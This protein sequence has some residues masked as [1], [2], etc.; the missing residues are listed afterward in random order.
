MSSPP[1]PEPDQP[2]TCGAAPAGQPRRRRLASGLADAPC[3]GRGQAGRGADRRSDPRGG[4]EAQSSLSSCRAGASGGGQCFDVRTLIRPRSVIRDVRHH[5][6]SPTL[7]EAHHRNASRSRQ[8]PPVELDPLD[9][10]CP[11]SCS[12]PAIR[13]DH[14]REFST[15][16][17]VGP[18]P[19]VRGRRR[20][21]TPAFPRMSQRTFVIFIIRKPAGPNPQIETHPRPGGTISAGSARSELEPV[22]RRRP[23]LARPRQRPGWAEAPG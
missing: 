1:R 18:V 3:P 22:A 15:T 9:A 8:A 5:R 13:T 7:R 10:T 2:T 21:N 20:C 19:Y 23:V 14:D 11:P 17:R 4:Y 16:K 6:S 12:S